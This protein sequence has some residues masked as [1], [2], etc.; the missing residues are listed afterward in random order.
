MPLLGSEH[1]SSRKAVFVRTRWFLLITL[2]LFAAAV[3]GI[4]VVSSGD[5]APQKERFVQEH[6]V[7]I[8][9]DAR[10]VQISSTMPMPS[11]HARRLSAMLEQGSMP[12]QATTGEILT[13]TECTPDKDSISRC[14]NE[15]RLAGGS[16]IVLRHPHRMAHVP[17]LAPG[18][19]VRLLPLDS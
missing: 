16:T 2:V 8:P 4:S 19:T 7:S 9:S 17:C 12:S 10:V 15:V 13:D 18:E 3:T 14:R 1:V 6:P 5:R 11:A